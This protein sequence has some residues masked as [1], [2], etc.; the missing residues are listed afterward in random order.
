M[1]TLLLPWENTAAIFLGCDRIVL[2]LQLRGNGIDLSPPFLFRAI[3]VI[4]GNPLRFF[5]G[6]GSGLQKVRKNYY[7]KSRSLKVL[8]GR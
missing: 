7:E 5:V 2:C 3:Y 8:C 6:R 4:R 1:A